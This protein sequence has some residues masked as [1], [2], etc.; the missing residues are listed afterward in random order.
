[1][2][3]GGQRLRRVARRLLLATL[4]AAAA[5]GVLWFRGL[6]RGAPPAPAP[7]DE[8]TPAGAEMVT[9]DFRHVEIR[10][11]RTVWVLEAKRA[12]VR[13]EKARLTAVKITWYGEPGSVP[14]VL[15]SDGGKIDFA[16]RSAL[17][18]GHVRA[19]R[20]DG[21]VLE[22]ERLFFDEASKLLQA[23]SPVLISSPTFSFRG[24][25]LTANLAQRWVRL[26]GRVD[27][28][29]RGGVA[30]APGNS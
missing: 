30:P 25:S 11:D 7:V 18:V 4:V 19:E 21:G 22:T 24:T 10:M 28:E 27:G 1:M 15:T 14:V 23:P 16:K 6:D 20:G 5:A 12:E 17:L 13:A 3:A 8:A 26:T 2:S 29:I 9:R